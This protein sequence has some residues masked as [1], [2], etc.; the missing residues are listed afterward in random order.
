MSTAKT[1]I[2]AAISS[3][4]ATMTLLSPPAHADVRA[5][6]L[7]KQIQIL[8]RALSDLQKQVQSL[9][10][11]K[12]EITPAPVSEAPASDDATTRGATQADIDGLRAD[13]ENYKYDRERERERQTAKTTRDTTVFGTVQVRYQAQSEGASNG[14]PAPNSE[15]YSTF[16]VPTALTGLRGNLYRDYV[17][18]KNLEYQV[19]FGYKKRGTVA[20]SGDASDFNLL[21]AYVRYNFLPTDDGLEGDRLTLTV[22]QQLLPFGTEAQAAEDLRPTINVATAPGRLGLFNR[23]IGAILRGDFKPYVDYAANYRAPLLEY[24]FGVV[25]GSYSNKLDNNN[26]KA[27][28]ARLAS[29]LPVDYASWL[30]E[31][32]LGASLYRGSHV[33]GNSAGTKLAGHGRNDIYGFDVYYNHA[34]YG[35]TYEYWRGRTDLATLAGADTGTARSNGHTLTLFYTLGDQFFNSVKSSAKYDDWWPQSI[36]SYYRLDYY[37]PNTGDALAGVGGK[38]SHALRVHT[39]GFNWFFAQTTKLQVGL[40]R[41]DYLHKVAGKDT[42]EF[43]TQ[44]QYTF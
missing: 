19:S 7:Q 33:V 9:E 2:A 35:V 13:F 29:T 18:G 3:L 26:G 15:R 31:L 30:R 32:K 41:Y 38:G 39:L 4:M 22:G 42:T 10:K 12:P 1:R 37:N 20:E 11:E 25:N 23:Q 44:L 36:Q 8:Q 6:E 21:D 14:N 34:P 27:V 16:E 43:Q 40:N 17:A 24:A 5:E 28:T